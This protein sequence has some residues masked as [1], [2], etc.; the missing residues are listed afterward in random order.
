MYQDCSTGTFGDLTGQERKKGATTIR[1]RRLH[2]DVHM[3]T[4]GCSLS[5]VI[6]SAVSPL[7]VDYAAPA[8]ILVAACVFD[9]FVQLVVPPLDASGVQGFGPMDRSATASIVAWKLRPKPES[10]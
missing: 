2:Q 9:I 5:S 4:D 7:T 3:P 6:R 1:Q 10:A 8:R